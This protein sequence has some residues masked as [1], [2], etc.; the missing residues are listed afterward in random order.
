MAFINTDWNDE[1]DDD[2]YGSPIGISPAMKE[3]IRDAEFEQEK[4]QMENRERSNRSNGGETEG[5][6]PMISLDEAIIH[7]E[8][9]VLPKMECSACKDEHIQLLEWLKE[10]RDLRETAAKLKEAVK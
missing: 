5:G 6:I 4:G 10:L 1:L 3:S 7:L 2:I 8:E 9:D